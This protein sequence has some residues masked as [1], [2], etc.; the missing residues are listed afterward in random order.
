MADHHIVNDGL[1]LIRDIA[2]DS[3]QKVADKVNPSED[4]LKNID[5]PEEDNTWHDVP[6]IK[7]Q[8]KDKYHQAKPTD[9]QGLKD[10]A[11]DAKSTGQNSGSNRGGAKEALKTGFNNLKGQAQSN[12]PD[13]QQDEAQHKKEQG[14]QKARQTRDQ[15]K[16]Y[17]KN[18]MPQERREQVIHRLKKMIVE[19]QGNSDCAF[20]RQC[21]VDNLLT[22]LKTSKLL[23]LS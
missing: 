12:V 9:R 18:K 13:D 17:L 11:R 4:E 16:D 10:A 8:V 1:V 6:D 15:A 22:I 5:E 3:A 19:I 2:G 7:G 14:K 23:T 20:R 21:L